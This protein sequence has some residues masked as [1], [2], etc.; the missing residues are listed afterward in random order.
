MGFL[1]VYSL[2][3]DGSSSLS[4]SMVASLELP[5]IESV[6]PTHYGSRDE[7]LAV[8]LECCI[9]L[10]YQ[11]VTKGTFVQGPPSVFEV[12][13]TGRILQLRLRLPYDF[14]LDDWRYAVAP[15]S[16][17]CIR[18]QPILR[19]VS[20]PKDE[21]IICLNVS[22]SDWGAGSRW[23]HRSGNSGDRGAASGTRLVAISLFQSS[24]TTFFDRE[25]EAA[26]FQSPFD[27]IDVLDF[28]PA[29]LNQS[30]PL[31]PHNKKEEDIVDTNIWKYQAQ[32]SNEFTPGFR[33][34]DKWMGQASEAIAPYISA[35][36]R[37]EQ[38]YD[39]NS[40]CPTVWA[41]DE[42]FV[43]EKRIDTG[44]LQSVTVV[45]F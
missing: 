12:S 13:N 27:Y 19:L 22:W 3:L 43:I 6:P 37:D 18:V 15:F 40:G 33:Q 25:D 11:P 9:D 32:S 38:L 4:V 36:F 45:T 31:D 7:P 34:D 35:Q 30:R 5:V 44:S 20:Q 8:K 16:S 1:D 21:G 29:F 23:L 2:Q 26:Y 10:A 14:G 42:H 17:L 28:H 41:D 24:Q 39:M